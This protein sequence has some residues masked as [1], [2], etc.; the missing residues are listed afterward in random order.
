MACIL[1]LAHL[2]DDFQHKVDVANM[3]RSYRR[4]PRGEAPAVNGGSAPGICHF[5]N[6]GRENYDWEDLTLVS[7]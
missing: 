5:C 1:Q 2:C 7:K 3:E 6:A 4:G